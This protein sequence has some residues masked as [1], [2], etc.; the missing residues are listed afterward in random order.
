MNYL[1]HKEKIR[2]IMLATLTTG[3]I[4]FIQPVFADSQ[5][6]YDPVSNAVHIPKVHVGEDQYE[7]QMKFEP[8][9]N[10]FVLTEAK[11]ISMLTFKDRDNPDVSWTL[12]LSELIAQLPS[13]DI[14]VFDPVEN[15]N[16]TFRGVST[17]ALLDLIYG[18]GWQERE[19]ILTTA[20][21]GSQ[22]SLAVER[23]L[24]Y[25]S[26]V[27]YE[28]VDRP[29]F[30]LVKASDGKLVELGPFFLIWDNITFPEVK[31]SVS[32]GWPWQLVSFELAK[33]ADLFANSAPPEGSPENVKSGFLAAREF[34]MGCHKVNGEGGTRAPDLIQADLVADHTADRIKELITDIDEAP[35]SGMVLR[36][37]IPDREQVADDIIAYLK[38]MDAAR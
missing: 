25:E 10:R 22:S 2:S 8:E 31:A 29:Q 12:T 16:K 20:L 34:C 3:L 27:A 7:V 32:Y 30:I 35:V 1:L 4:T 9:Q 23:F 36:D 19:E 6:T 38:A 18:E 24:K 17:N 11:L 28:Q 15:R 14:E 5:V 33:F 26:Y 21:D 13:R 37:E